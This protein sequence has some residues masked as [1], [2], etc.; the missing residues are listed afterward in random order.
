VDATDYYD[1]FGTGEIVIGIRAYQWGWEYFYPKNIDLNYNV[2]SSYGSFI[3]NSI[4][5]NNTT[6][7]NLEAAVLWKY[8]QNKTTAQV[9]TPAH[10]I[11]SPNNEDSSLNNI[12]FSH[13]GNAISKDVSS[14]KRI[15]ASSKISS[16][17]IPADT[18]SNNTLFR[19]IN[20]LYLSPSSLNN[21]SYFYGTT[22]QHNFA[23]TDSLLP[24]YSTL[25]DKRS[26]DKFFSY[27]L[28]TEGNNNSPLQGIN[29]SGT[30]DTHK[31]TSDYGLN[32]MPNNNSIFLSKF[33][34]DYSRTFLL[35]S[36]TDKKKTGNP[37]KIYDETKKI[38]SKGTPKVSYIDELVSNSQN[39]FFSWNIFN[40]SINYQQQDINSGN[41]KFLSFEKNTRLVAN[42]TAA[43]ITNDLAGNDKLRKVAPDAYS[44]YLGSSM[45]WVDLGLLRKITTSTL[46]SST[47]RNPLSTTNTT[48]KNLSY[49]RVNQFSSSETP[50]ILRGKEEMAPDYL[51]NT[52][53]HSFWKNISLNKGYSL[54]QG[55][56]QMASTFYL[57]TILEYSEYD[58]RNWQ[59]LESLE[60]AYWE[61]NYFSSVHDDYLNV[62]TG[63]KSPLLFDKVQTLF[64][65]N[66]RVRGDKLV[67]LVVAFF[68]VPAK[69][70]YLAFPQNLELKNVTVNCNNTLFIAQNLPLVNFFSSTKDSLEY[71]YLSETF[72][73]DLEGNVTKPKYKYISKFDTSNKNNLPVFSPNLFLVPSSSNILNMSLY[74]NESLLEVPEN[75]YE[76]AKK[77]K[78]FIFKKLSK[79]FF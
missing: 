31:N 5:Y 76:G 27:T 29:S 78:V 39:N 32:L 12:D 41:L 18:A 3:G 16:T 79:C 9:N 67:G 8:Y 24:N 47:N 13:V 15:Q 22:R 26:L 36:L 55:N 56:L 6:Q 58:F 4:K 54:Q 25:V 40:D 38:S 14:F 1:G 69:L 50:E 28:N 68:N 37:V 42:K 51:F 59:A 73:S 20:N 2:K 71:I 33:L 17:S 21:D 43:S 74:N 45:N 72:Y 70:I 65:S 77:L 49:D 52:Y 66:T 46:S 53:W 57:P 44:A 7:T 64:N 60:D 63:T 35:N 19:K 10:L 30:P 61:S 75:S 34:S 11:L 62:F 23:S 48:F